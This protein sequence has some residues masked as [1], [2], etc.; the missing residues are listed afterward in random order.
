MSMMKVRLLHGCIHVNADDHAVELESVGRFMTRVGQNHVL[1]YAGVVSLE[2]SEAR[3]MI[4]R[5]MAVEVPAD[6]ELS[7]PIGSDDYI[8]PP[9]TVRDKNGHALGRF[10]DRWIV[11][12]VT[13]PNLK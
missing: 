6:T 8:L 3:A 5:G 13:P 2:E 10:G 12:G 4:A 9:T 1:H 7:P 11:V